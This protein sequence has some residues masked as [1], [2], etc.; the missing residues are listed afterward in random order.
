MPAF[1]LDG[2]GGR[3]AL[4]GSCSF[5]FCCECRLAWHGLQPC[6]NLASRWKAADDAGKAALRAKHGDRVMEEVESSQWVL[7]H[8]KPCPNCGTGT[9][10]NGG[11]NHITCLKCRHQWCWLCMSTYSQGHYS[12]GSCEQF[13]QDFFDEIE[14]TREEFEENYVVLNHW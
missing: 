1:L 5:S 7:D 4:C 13:S 9:E 2:E 8:T 11:C 12:N 10:K 14:L 6:A 3:L